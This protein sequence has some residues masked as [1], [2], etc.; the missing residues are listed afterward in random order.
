MEL[1]RLGVH[2]RL[3]IFLVTFWRMSITAGTAIEF[4]ICILDLFSLWTVSLQVRWSAFLSAKNEELLI[5]SL[6][7][8]HHL[9]YLKENH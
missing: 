6:S 5:L 2:M 9:E 8:F 3:S 7:N 1:M 4:H